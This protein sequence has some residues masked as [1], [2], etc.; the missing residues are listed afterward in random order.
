LILL[1]GATAQANA[2]CTPF[3]TDGPPSSEYTVTGMYSVAAVF[4]NPSENK[5]SQETQNTEVI[6]LKAE[7]AIAAA[8]FEALKEM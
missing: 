1:A 3:P 5:S 8:I 7:K 6:N 4:N 2:N